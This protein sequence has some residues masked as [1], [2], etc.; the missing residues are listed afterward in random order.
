MTGVQTCAL[1]ISFYSSTT[2]KKA[3]FNYFREEE[4]FNLDALLKPE[5][6]ETE[7]FVLK[8]NNLN[9]IKYSPEFLTNKDPKTP[10]NRILTSLFQPERL[11]F[12]LKYGIAYIQEE[13]E[14]RKHIMRYPQIFATKAI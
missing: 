4:L 8:D 9:T 11:K 10:C 5:N 3:S 7:N 13:G 1:P 12:L 2:Y 14:I 6:D